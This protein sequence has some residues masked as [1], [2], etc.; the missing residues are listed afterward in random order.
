MRIGIC[1]PAPLEVVNDYIY[2]YSC[3]CTYI[4]REVV[5]CLCMDRSLSG[6]RRE[7]VGL[8]SYNIPTG[9]RLGPR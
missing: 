2:I 3:D 1:E 8:G 4:V 6:Q 9:N 7:V 5:L